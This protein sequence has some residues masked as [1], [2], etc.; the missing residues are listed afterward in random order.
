MESVALKQP[1]GSDFM[2]ASKASSLAPFNKLIKKGVDEKSLNDLYHRLSGGCSA[3]DKFEQ[4][5]IHAFFEAVESFMQD[6]SQL[7]RL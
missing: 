4:A 1:A 5:A 7:I 3:V 6:G 2:P